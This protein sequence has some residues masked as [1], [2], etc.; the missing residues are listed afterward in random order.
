MPA[1][2]VS[3]EA[4]ICR[5]CLCDD[6]EKQN[7]LISPCKCAGTMGFIH[8]LCLKEWIVNRRSTRE[9]PCVKTYYWRSLDCE[10]CKGIFPD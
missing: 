1:L 3:N 10:L 7:P 9:S 5:I 2:Q 4:I 8:V 6:Q